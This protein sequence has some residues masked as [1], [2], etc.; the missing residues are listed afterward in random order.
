MNARRYKCFFCVKIILTASRENAQWGCFDH[1]FF[2]A[3]EICPGRV[4]E[5]QLY[6]L[7]CFSNASTSEVV[8]KSCNRVP[9]VFFALLILLGGNLLQ[10]QLSQTQNHPDSCFEILSSHQYLAHCQANC[11][12]IQFIV[13]FKTYFGSISLSVMI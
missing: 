6:G 3:S 12:T 13:I 8:T 10:W 4:P 5:P 1:P 7:A 11:T 9:V 2:C